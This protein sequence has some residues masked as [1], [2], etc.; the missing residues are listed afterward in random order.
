M[1]QFQKYLYSCTQSDI[2][3]FLFSTTREK[4]SYFDIFFISYDLSFVTRQLLDYLFSTV[5]VYLKN[6]SNKKHLSQHCVQ[7]D[8]GERVRK[9]HSSSFFLLNILSPMIEIFELKVKNRQKRFSCASS[10]TKMQ[11]VYLFIHLFLLVGG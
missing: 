6:N 8:Q 5:C 9:C 7:K 1:N 10:K 4:L 2:L 3:H 11:F